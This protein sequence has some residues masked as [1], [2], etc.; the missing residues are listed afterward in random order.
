MQKTGAGGKGA[1][2]K[3]QTG[4]GCARPWLTLADDVTVVLRAAGQDRRSP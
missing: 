1:H 3:N 4:R 2:G